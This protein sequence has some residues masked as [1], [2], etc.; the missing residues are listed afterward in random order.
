MKGIDMDPKADIALIGLA[1]IGA[2]VLLVVL[3][4]I[5]RA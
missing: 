1:V 3:R 5:K 4:I 2:V